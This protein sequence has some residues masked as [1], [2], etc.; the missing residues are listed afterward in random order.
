MGVA[1]QHPL[2]LKLPHPAACCHQKLCYP[3]PL[4][5]LSASSFVS[6]IFDMW[7]FH[8]LPVLILQSNLW[9]QEGVVHSKLMRQFLTALVGTNEEGIV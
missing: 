5:H 7:E 3:H 8:P 4:C 2:L 6:L 9:I 1:Q